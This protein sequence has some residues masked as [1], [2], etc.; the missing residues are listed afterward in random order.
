MSKADQ[1]KVQDERKQV[2]QTAKGRGK[3]SKKPAGMLV[4]AIKA[5]KAKIKAQT[6]TISDMKAKFD[7]EPDDPV[8]DDAVDSF[9]GRK[10]KK[11]SNKIKTKYDSDK[12]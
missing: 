3:N 6:I 4:R 2:G 1:A 9:S 7:I 12:E 10:E 8:T 11:K 5:M